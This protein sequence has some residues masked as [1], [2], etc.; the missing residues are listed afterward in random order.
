MNQVGRCVSHPDFGFPCD[1]PEV[2]AH[3]GPIRKGGH[4]DRPGGRP[5]KEI[6]KLGVPFGIDQ[7]VAGDGLDQQ[8]LIFRSIV[9]G[10]GTGRLFPD[11]VVCSEEP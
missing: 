8:Q 7:P 11:L 2:A 1:F 9:Q 4:I 5:G 10:V 3:N 6:G